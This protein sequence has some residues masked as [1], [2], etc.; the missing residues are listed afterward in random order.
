MKDF[1]VVVNFTGEKFVSDVYDIHGRD[2]LLYHPEHGFG[3]YSTAMENEG[4]PAIT[5]WE[6][7]KE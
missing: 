4:K 7:E 3:W 1:K 2:F 6:E 5:L